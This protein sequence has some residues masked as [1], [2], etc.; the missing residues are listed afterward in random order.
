MTILTMG[1]EEEFV[2]VDRVTRAPAHRAPEVIRRATREFG[3][4]VQAELF[5][6]QIEI[7]TCP[8]PFVRDSSPRE[9]ARRSSS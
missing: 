9:G 8:P 1:A 6:A 2:L 7:C 3:A 5:N 4:P